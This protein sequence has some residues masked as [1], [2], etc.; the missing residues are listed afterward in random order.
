MATYVA[1]MRNITRWTGRS[2]IVFRCAVGAITATPLPLVE[3]AM[4]A[5]PELTT[6]LVNMMGAPLDGC[7]HPGVVG[8]PAMA[9][10]AIPIVAKAMGWA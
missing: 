10:T 8:Q 5:A 6:V 3:R 2:D 4:A 9:A 1:F 7:G